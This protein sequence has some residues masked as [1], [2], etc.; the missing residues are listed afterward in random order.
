MEM[1]SRLNN[2]MYIMVSL[3]G[4]YAVT[5]LG[6]MILALLLF[7]MQISEK[8]VDVGILVIYFL[9]CFIAGY[10]IGK[11]KKNRKFLW[12][13]VTGVCYYIILMAVSFL[14]YKTLGE[15]GND[16]ITTFFIC[17]GS[18]TLGGMVS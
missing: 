4:G 10:M 11:M 1:K 12:G 6:I 17:G 16:L 8:A 9:A 5:F 15:N 2:V 18:S 7:L 3:L 14:T 13:M